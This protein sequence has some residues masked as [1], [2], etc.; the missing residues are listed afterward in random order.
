MNY[1]L[2]QSDFDKLFQSSLLDVHTPGLDGLSSMAV[3]ISEVN[4]NRKQNITIQQEELNVFF[5]KL[6]DN[7]NKLCKNGSLINGLTGIAIGIECNS[8]YLEQNMNLDL[9]KLLHSFHNYINIFLEKD[10]H[11]NK[12]DFLYGYLGMANYLLESE[13]CSKEIKKSVSDK[14]IS[15]LDLSKVNNYSNCYSWI[16]Y[17]ELNYISLRD[18]K[19]NG[20]C[21]INLG[22]AHGISS[23]IMILSKIYKFENS[24]CKDLIIKAVKFIESMQ[25]KNQIYCFGRYS[26][27][28][29]T[30]STTLSWCNGDLG[31]GY[32]IIYAGIAIND[33]A[34]LR[35]GKSIVN[36]TLKI[37]LDNSRVFNGC[38]C[39]GIIG[40]S[41]IYFKCYILTGDINYLY[42][43]IYWKCEYL[44]FLNNDNLNLMANFNIIKNHNNNLQDHYTGITGILSTYNFLENLKLPYWSKFVLC[45]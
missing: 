11:E 23:I 20:S 34:L 45:I 10:L 21:P 32:S 1:Y 2:I 38:L 17:F 36:N 28:I 14:V 24:I 31:I 3:L 9:H 13:F 41:M 29:N 27:S 43:F 40:I 44:K 15:T 6:F 37:N 5:N 4:L 26:D 25:F 12:F 22:F 39:H 8:N 19:E 33:P 18:R 16:N 42:K 7:T 30:N 35:F